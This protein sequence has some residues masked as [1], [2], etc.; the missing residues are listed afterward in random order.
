MKITQISANF[1]AKKATKQNAKNNA[2][3]SR[4]YTPES[5]SEI[6][7]YRAENGQVLK[8][9]D[10]K[11]LFNVE[12]ISNAKIGSKFLLK[13]TDPE[14]SDLTIL[15]KPE[16][17][18]NS[19]KEDLNYTII[20]E[21]PTFTGNIFGSIR[22]D[23]RGTD[24]TMKSAYSD[25]WHKGMI[26]KVRPDS[27]SS[28]IKSDYN[29][30]IPSDG[31]GTRYRDITLL[32]GG[33]TKPASKIPA[34]LGNENMSL[35]QNIL[36]N[37]ARTSKLEG[38]DTIEVKPAQGSAFA[39]LE[40]LKS[41]QIPTD[42]P[43]VFSWGDNFSDIN[44]SKIILQHEK[45]NSGMTIL[46][47]PV[48]KE[49]VK[50]LSAVKINNTEDMEILEFTEKPKE[51]E[52]I[53]Y[54]SIPEFDDNCLSA[55]GPYILSAQAL[56][57][58]KED[59]TNNPDLFKAEDGSFDFSRKVIGN[60]LIAMKNNEIK[61]EEGN[62]LKMRAYVKPK[63]ETWSD[64]GSEKD[65]TQSMIAIK[66]GGFSNLLPEIKKSISKNV[67][68]NHNITFDVKTKEKLQKFQQKYQINLQNAIIY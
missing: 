32:Q 22:K 35:V 64:L 62:A 19:K 47:L 12:N 11:N 18:L 24:Y 14:F 61:D 26:D 54:Y 27:I 13:P 53:D 15:F 67:D 44:I 29:F 65:F 8:A 57:R 55:V 38:F 50:A 4:H 52:V 51:K 49:R 1:G 33:V 68:K 2:I 63:K 46:T 66:K 41:G 37:F 9:K 30:F 23:E 25:F 21:M 40:G 20:N 42:K 58:V 28:K 43:M 45:N 34:K 6:K 36:V 56:Q 59:Y 60:L 3:T 7:S 10:S 48:D 16:T 39:F 31:D 17:V 5:V